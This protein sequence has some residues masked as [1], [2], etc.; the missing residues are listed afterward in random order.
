MN[1]DEYSKFMGEVLSAVEELPTLIS[2]VMLLEGQQPA[3]ALGGICA[4]IGHRVE[5]WKIRF[6]KILD[7]QQS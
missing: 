5:E 2:N 3:F 4:T 1:N 6:Q 7:E